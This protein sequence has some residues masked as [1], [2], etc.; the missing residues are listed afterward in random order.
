MI[1]QAVMSG[2]VGWSWV[3]GM[4]DKSSGDEVLDDHLGLDT[5]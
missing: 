1:S 4:E 5:K 2:V 3:R